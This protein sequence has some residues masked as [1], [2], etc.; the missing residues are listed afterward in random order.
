MILL[1]II[2]GI[3]IVVGIGLVIA[4]VWLWIKLWNHLNDNDQRKSD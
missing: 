4:Y 3:A 1:N 2:N